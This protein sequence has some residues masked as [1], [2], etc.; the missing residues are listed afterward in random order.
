MY[1]MQ[2]VYSQIRN[3]YTPYQKNR[4]HYQLHSAKEGWNM[5]VM[6]RMKKVRAVYFG[7]ILWY[8]QLRIALHRYYVISDI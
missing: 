5:I 4:I 7:Q 8:R 1:H 3:S 6:N 2:Y